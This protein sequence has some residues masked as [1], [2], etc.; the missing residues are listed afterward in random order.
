M[1]TR[2]SLVSAEV[3]VSSNETYGVQALRRLGEAHR[4][5]MVAYFTV[6]RTAPADTWK[7]GAGPSEVGNVN[8]LPVE[9][10]ILITLLS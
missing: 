3:A 8:G 1:I 2:T 5:A 4:L 9:R 10:R 7:A 6:T